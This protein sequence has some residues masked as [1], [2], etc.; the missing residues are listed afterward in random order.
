MLCN[1]A[2]ATNTT[3]TALGRQERIDK[4]KAI[5]NLRHSHV[6]GYV[7]STRQSFETQMADDAVRL[8]Y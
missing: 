4:I 5:Q 2:P 3:G 8:I 7:T 6:V 1:P